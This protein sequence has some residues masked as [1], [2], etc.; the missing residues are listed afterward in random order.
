V[1]VQFRLNLL[2]L[3]GQR[4]DTYVDVLNVFALRTVTTVGQE[5]GRDFALPRDRMAPFRIRLGVNYRY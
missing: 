5:D 4:L 3:I 1:N 2:P